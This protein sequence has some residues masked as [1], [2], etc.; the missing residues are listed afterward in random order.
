MTISSRRPIKIGESAAIWNFYEQ[1]F[2]N[3]QQTACKLIAKA[4]VKA[5][6]P[7][8]QSTHPY[9]GSDEK[10][11]DWWPKAW[12]PTKEDKVRHKEPDHLYKR[13]R[14]HL[15]AHILRLVVEPNGKQHSDIQKIG[16]NVKKLEET[17][18]EALSSFFM[19]NEANAKKRPYLNEIFKVA[20]FEERY[21]NGEIDGSTEVYVMAED[22]LAEP[23]S[24][25]SENE[26]AGVCRDDEDHGGPRSKPAPAQGLQHTA[27]IEN[28]P[29]PTLRGNAYLGDISVRNTQFAQPMMADMAAQ[30]HSFV[31]NG[32][33][34][35]HAAQPVTSAGASS[36]PLDLVASPHDNTG[37]RPSV[38]SEYASPGTSMYPQQ[39]S[40]PAT[41]ASAPPPMYPYAAQQAASQ[42]ASFVSQPVTMSSSQTFMSSPFEGSA[43]SEYD[44]SANAMFR[45]S[46]LPQAPVSQQQGYGYT[47]PDDGQAMRALTQVVDSVHRAP[48]Q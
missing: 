6:E 20:R 25:T 24:Y 18:V 8:K 39:W 14:V 5:V 15:L 7:K 46:E 27:T 38:Y 43:R 35:V 21:K 2:K 19:D 23:E 45:A 42:P 37:R 22:K 9:T 34:S 1:R 40:T 44:P 31:E 16:L 32:G 36:M 11:P 17:T 10:A 48:M 28:G 29:A 41:G 33:I 3:C 47:L 26:E 12:G 13:E 30:Q 4:W